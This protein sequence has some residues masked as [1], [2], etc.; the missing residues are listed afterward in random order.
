MPILALLSLLIGLP[1]LLFR[2]HHLSGVLWLSIPISLYSFVGNFAP[3]FEVGV[4]YILTAEQ[5]LNG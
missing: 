3:F 1:L 5:E 4:G 2:I